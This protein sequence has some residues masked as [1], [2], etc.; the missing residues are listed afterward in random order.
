MSTIK[1]STEKI[2]HIMKFADKIYKTNDFQLIILTSSYFY[3]L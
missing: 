3:D 2:Q 1:F